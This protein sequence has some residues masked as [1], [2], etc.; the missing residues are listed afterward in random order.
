MKDFNVYVI[1]SGSPLANLKKTLD[2]C[3][4][5]QYAGIIYRSHRRHRFDRRV[6]TEKEETRKTIIFCPSST[7]ETLVEK[8]PE[9]KEHVVDYNWDSFPVP[10]DEN[11]ETWNL[12]VS[13]VPNDYT[14]TAAESMVTDTLSVVLPKKD[15]QGNSNFTIDFVTRLRETGEI[16]GFGHLD[17]ADHVSRET[18]KL[19]KIVLHNTPV[20]FYENKEQRR[21]MTCVWR[22]KLPKSMPIE[23]RAPSDIGMM[24]RPTRILQ[25]AQMIDLNRH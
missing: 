15:E 8:H 12:H 25:R 3:G 1:H 11:S 4:G 24:G 22:R 7:I 23:R 13:G 20:P 14:A 21:M 10:T 16:Y 18:I 9:Y 17:F 19:C 6:I 2:N 5:F